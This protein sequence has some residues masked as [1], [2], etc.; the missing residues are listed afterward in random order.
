MPHVIF[1][2]ILQSGAA[3]PLFLL[4][5]SWK[6]VREIMVTLKLFGECRVLHHQERVSRVCQNSQFCCRKCLLLYRVKSCVNF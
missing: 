1:I 5:K 4:N 2:A 6:K 3:L